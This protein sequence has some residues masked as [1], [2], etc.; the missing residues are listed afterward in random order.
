MFLDTDKT[1]HKDIIEIEH[2]IDIKIVLTFFD[3][4]LFK[5]SLIAFLKLRCGLII[6]L[7]L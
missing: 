4:K 6:L 1:K 7:T 5:D 3:H 2:A